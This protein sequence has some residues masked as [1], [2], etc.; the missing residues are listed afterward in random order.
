MGDAL[1]AAAAEAGVRITLLDTLYLHGGLDADGY[2][3]LAGVQRRFGDRSLDAWADR[4]TARPTGDRV[5]VGAAVHSVRAVDPASIAKVAAW[6][7]EHGAPLHAHVSEQPIENERC[8]A[9]HG[10]DPTPVLDRAGALATRFTAVHATHLTSADIDTLGAAR[11]TACFCPT[12]ERDL[13]DGIGP[14]RRLVDAG[15]RLAIGSDSHAVVDPFEE[16]RAIEL[17]ERLARRERGV[18]P[19]SVL[20]GAATDGHAC[21]GWDDA[22]AIEIGRRADLVTLTLDSPRT[23]GARPDSLPE[24]AVFSAGAADVTHVTVD[25]ADVVVDGRHRTV[26]VAAELAGAIAEVVG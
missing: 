1:V 5:R 4:V 16:M 9:H 11:A 18:L 17:D 22:G 26:D 8:R 23:A 10:T 7:S 25:G 19:T 3:P 12:T 21:L 20:L 24:A 15:A 2:R 13:G 14:A 6:A